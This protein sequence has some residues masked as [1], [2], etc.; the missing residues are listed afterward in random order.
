MK[1]TNLDRAPEHLTKASD[2]L[3]SRMLASLLHT[4]MV[5][6]APEGL[7]AAMQK[8]LDKFQEWDGAGQEPNWLLDC[9]H[10][11]MSAIRAHASNLELW[12]KAEGNEEYITELRRVGQAMKN[13]LRSS[14]DRYLKRPQQQPAAPVVEKPKAK[15]YQVD[16]DANPWLLE[17]TCPDPACKRCALKAAQDAVRQAEAEAQKA[18]EVSSEGDVSVFQRDQRERTARKQAARDAK[19]EAASKEPI[20]VLDNVP[21]VGRMEVFQTSNQDQVDAEVAVLL[22]LCTNYRRQHDPDSRSATAIMHEINFAVN[23]L[24]VWNAVRDVPGKP[25]VPEWSTRDTGVAMHFI[26]GAEPGRS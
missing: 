22:R 12:G 1:P 14:G 3:S 25:H 2:P 23:N 8:T 13:H 18:L 7:L 10:E 11:N 20:M 17:C 9:T 4:M 5:K 6:D 26:G 19:I 16:M 15:A 24:R 21:G